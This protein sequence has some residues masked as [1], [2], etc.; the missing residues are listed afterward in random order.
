V[1]YLLA[2]HRRDQVGLGEIPLI[3]ARALAEIAA[4][5]AMIGVAM[6]VTYLFPGRHFWHGEVSRDAAYSPV[7]F[8]ATLISEVGMYILW[9]V[10]GVQRQHL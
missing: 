6:L 1:A 3:I 4:F 2:S 8:A 5:A 7:V 9:R 10:L